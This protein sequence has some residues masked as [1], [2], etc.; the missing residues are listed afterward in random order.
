[1]RIT[2]N[3]AAMIDKVS[4]TNFKSLR[5]VDAELRR[6]MVIVGPNGSGKTSL[7]DGLH[8]LAQATQQSIASIMSG[9]FAPPNLR[10]R[11]AEGPMEL[12]LSG[13][14]HGVNARV[15]LEITCND[16]ADARPAWRATVTRRWGEAEEET[17]EPPSSM[18]AKL[19]AKT[20]TRAL[21]TGER[22]RSRESCRIVQRRGDTSSGG[23]RRR[24]GVGSGRSRGPL[25][26]H[27]SVNPERCERGH[28]DAR[29]DP[30]SSGQG[31]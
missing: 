9:V 1:M 6:F 23:R 29:A 11:S 17:S 26:R 18:L 8:Y 10:S 14:Y 25:S 19:R 7:L 31:P 3:R 30:H 20:A 24:L 22:G 13:R 16:G 21:E 15:E 2:W 27:L 4:F 12:A 5:R 28:P